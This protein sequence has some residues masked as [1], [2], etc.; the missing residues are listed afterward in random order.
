LLITFQDQYRAVQALAKLSDTLST[1]KFKTDVNVGGS[2][3]MAVLGRSPGRVSRFT[4][5]VAYN[6][7]TGAGQYYQIP[8]DADTPKEVLAYNGAS[9]TSL[10]E[11]VDELTWRQ[12]NRVVLTGPATHF[13]VQGTDEIGLYPAPAANVSEGLELIF[14][15][16]QLKLI[17]DDYTTGTVAIVNGTTTLT[18]S[19]A[20]FTEQMIG[21]AIELTDG[22]DGNFYKLSAFTSNS[23]MTIDNYY[24][25]LTV[26]AATFRI[27][28][29]M[30]I[31]E[32]YLQA[33]VDYAMWRYELGHDTTKAQI[34]RDSYQEQLKDCK[35]N[36]GR[37]SASSIVNA[38]K[39]IRQYNP[40]ID[41]PIV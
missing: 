36:Y 4:D 24:Q 8:K 6:T 38:S 7:V 29:V 21:R 32:E 2:R 18:H 26:T 12:M 40:L 31:P 10:I 14:E 39:T 22:S 16:R 1:A 11:V 23:I 33:P 3:F 28:E 19:A 37:K 35:S 30:D 15:K 34:F 5:L 13:F 41:T 17:Q 25:G 20:G 27:G 9:W